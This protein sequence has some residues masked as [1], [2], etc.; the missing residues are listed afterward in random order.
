MDQGCCW[1]SMLS[2]EC[3]DELEIESGGSLEMA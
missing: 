2:A 1:Y 3:W